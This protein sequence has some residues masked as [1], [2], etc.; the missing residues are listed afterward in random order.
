MSAVFLIQSCPPSPGEFL[1]DYMIKLKISRHMATKYSL[2]LHGAKLTRGR[3]PKFYYDEK[4]IQLDI[5]IGDK[6]VRAVIQKNM[7]LEKII[8][9]NPPENYECI[10]SY[11]IRVNNNKKYGKRD[12]LLAL[13]LKHNPRISFVGDT[14]V[15]QQQMYESL[16]YD[17]PP[18]LLELLDE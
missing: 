8:M 2:I 4:K 7:E 15:Y 16:N 5:L 13:V 6:Q 9:E 12:V 1:C 11:E 17:I 18:D 14:F 10:Y 3:D